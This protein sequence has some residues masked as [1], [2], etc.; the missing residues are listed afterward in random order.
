MII[1]PLLRVL[2]MP[3]AILNLIPMLAGFFASVS[4]TVAIFGQLQAAW[5]PGRRLSVEILANVYLYNRFQLTFP[6]YTIKIYSIHI[7]YVKS[8]N[9]PSH[10]VRS[11]VEMDIYIYK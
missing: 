11:I 10:V 7:V 8:T 4:H 6:S 2:G 5:R 9:H 1:F 3:H